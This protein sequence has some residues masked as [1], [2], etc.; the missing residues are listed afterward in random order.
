MRQEYVRVTCYLIRRFSLHSMKGLSRVVTLVV[1]DILQVQT[2][3]VRKT[4]CG[5]CWCG[6]PSWPPGNKV[7][8]RLSGS[9]GPS[10]GATISA[11]NSLVWRCPFST[12]YIHLFVCAAVH[13]FIC[14]CVYSNRKQKLSL[15]EKQASATPSLQNSPVP[16]NFIKARYIPYRRP[17]SPPVLLSPAPLNVS[18][19]RASQRAAAA[20]VPTDSCWSFSYSHT[21]LP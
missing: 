11:G 4:V 17:S 9:T 18:P 21:V 6:C 3:F 12:Q 8:S 15:P 13:P 16:C 1:L 20:T 19:V 5:R 7:W 10:L 2:T 14:L